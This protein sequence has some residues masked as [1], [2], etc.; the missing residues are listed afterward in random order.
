ML[1]SPVWWTSLERYPPIKVR[2]LAHT[3]GTRPVWI[4][5]AELA[6]TCGLTMARVREIGRMHSWDSVTFSEM[7][8]FCDGCRFDPTVPAQRKRVADYEYQCLTRHSQ[9][10]QWL[11]RSPRFQTEALPLI[12]LLANPPASPLQYVA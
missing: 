3:G 11:R 1:Q 9:P 10:M 4:S 8:K 12:H 5:D 6:I 7:R 2:L